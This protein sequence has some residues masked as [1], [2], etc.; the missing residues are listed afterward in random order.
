MYAVFRAYF[1]GLISS[2]AAISAFFYVQRQFVIVRPDQ[3][4]N[5]VLK[6][7]CIVVQCTSSTP[8]STLLA[9]L[10]LSRSLARALCDLPLPFDRTNYLSDCSGSTSLAS[11]LSPSD[12]D[13]FATM[14]PS[15]RYTGPMSMLLAFKRSHIPAAP[16]RNG[17]KS[18]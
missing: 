11:I 13:R 18:P 15:K 3:M 1:A 17:L 4:L 14:R 2:A 8:V 10:S 7:V 5:M 9:F 6:R 16:R 12:F